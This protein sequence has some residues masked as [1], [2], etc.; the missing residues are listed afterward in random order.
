MAVDG[1]IDYLELPSAEMAALSRF[2]QS[3]FGWG[4]IDYGP[5]YRG[6]EGA[7]IETGID[8]APDRAAAP[9]PVIRTSDIDAAEAAVRAAGG[10][11]TRP[12]FDFPGG[13]RFHF[14]APGGLEM[15]V[16]VAR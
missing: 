15:V 1:R 2:F 3:A 11:V 9:L 16:Y 4:G 6:V 10:V 12:Q 14:H 13:R 7:G 5:N 8:A